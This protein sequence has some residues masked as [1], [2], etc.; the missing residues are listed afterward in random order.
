MTVVSAGGGSVIVSKSITQNGTYNASSD[1]ADGYNPVTVNVPPTLFRQ[2]VDKSITSVT[3][4]DLYGGTSIGQYAFYNC[5]SLTSIEI[6]STVTSIGEEAFGW[7]ISL[8][9]ITFSSG[10][11]LSYINTRA[12]YHTSQLFKLILPSSLSRISS[13]AFYQGSGGYFKRLIFLGVT[14]PILD[15][16][17]AF[18][19][20]NNCPIYVPTPDNYKIAT[21]WVSIASRIFPLVSTAADLANIDTTTYTKACVIGTDE[22]YKEYTYDGTQW[23]EVV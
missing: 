16:A 7:C 20:T 9:S 4:Q 3:A 8:T 12:F 19:S 21:N 17:D 1:S 22:S 14:P 6:P 2:L 11:Q 10:S 13:L 15:N 18:N 23:N 5:S